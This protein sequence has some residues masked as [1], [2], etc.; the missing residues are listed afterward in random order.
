MAAL[1]EGCIHASL[2]RRDGRAGLD[3][4]Q[5]LEQVRLA[6]ACCISVSLQGLERCFS[7]QGADVS[8][9][10]PAP[11]HI[12]ML[13]ALGSSTK[14]M[15]EHATAHCKHLTM[16][17][18]PAKSG[19]NLLLLAPLLTSDPTANA[20]DASCL[21]DRLFANAT[22]P[23]RVV[24]CAISARSTSAA[25]GVFCVSTRR[26]AALASAVSGGGTNRR[27]SNRPGLS[28]A[29]STRSGLLVAPRT[30][31]VPLA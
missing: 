7:N 20:V 11:S 3:V 29:A 12:C 8:S 15:P 5:G 13:N 26:M 10:E 17:Q 25:S 27:M 23:H 2:R 30:T 18:L 28:S 16:Q 6:D 4:L 1:L 24:S 19:S 21:R 22:V 31:I 9:S 14:H